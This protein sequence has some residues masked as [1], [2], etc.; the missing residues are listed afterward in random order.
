MTW[1]VPTGVSGDW[2]RLNEAI[3]NNTSTRAVKSVPAKSWSPWITVTLPALQCGKI[4]FW[5]YYY[6]TGPTQVEV[7]RDGVWVQVFNQV[8][9]NNNAWTEV[10]FTAGSVSQ[11]RFRQYNGRSAAENTNLIELHF[12]ETG[13]PPPPPPPPAGR[14]TWKGCKLCYAWD[15]DVDAILAAGFNTAGCYTGI[16][17]TLLDE[18]AQKGLWVIPIGVYAAFYGGK[19]DLAGAIAFINKWKYHPAIAAWYFLDEPEQQSWCT[20][21]KQQTWY[22]ALKKADPD[23]DLLVSHTTNVHAPY[24]N[25]NPDAADHIALSDYPINDGVFDAGT[26]GW[27]GNWKG[28]MDYG[29]NRWNKD[30]G[31]R[32]A[33]AVVQAFREGVFR[34]PTGY[35]AGMIERF[36]AHG[37][38]LEKDGLAIYCWYMSAPNFGLSQK[39]AL[40]N[41]IRTA[42]AGFDWPHAPPEGEEVTYTCPYCGATFGTKKELDDHIASEHPDIRILD[43]N[44]SDFTGWKNGDHINGV[45][46]IEPAGQWRMAANAAAPGN[47]ARRYRDDLV[48]PPDKFTLRIKTY[49]DNIGTLADGDFAYIQYSTS[50]WRFYAQFA[51]D[52]LF[53][54]KAGGVDGEVG[55]N[56]VEQAAWH[57]WEF[58][59]DKSGG[60][61]VA[62]VDVYLDGVYQGTV[63]CNWETAATDGRCRYVQFGCSTNGM[64]SHVDYIMITSGYPEETFTTEEITCSVCS[65]VLKV[66]ISSITEHNED[67]LC[68]ICEAPIRTGTKVEIVS[69]PVIDQLRTDIGGL[70]EQIGQAESKVAELKG[71]IAEAKAKVD[72]IKKLL[73][74]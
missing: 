69:T 58:H 71:K 29:L 62:T 18:C 50:T 47:R 5:S 24:D 43:E 10:S 28:Y 33:M 45:S 44:C 21:D 8:E 48:S 17:K 55:I 7:Y 4:R 63:D 6:I 22:N 49:F 38:G 51:S 36:Q 42:L 37:I 2:S 66:T 16:T 1:R 15:F 32:A 64:L 67:L 41:E 40:L 70:D 72:E 30:T 39:A 46:E 20:K 52:G 65:S 74:M 68:P 35:I 59:V 56:I 25:W 23:R 26:E 19:G 73:G 13:E 12:E 60:E 31:G 14:F 61:A 57:V 53:I 11:A 9:I 34:D 3:D 54:K 27:Y